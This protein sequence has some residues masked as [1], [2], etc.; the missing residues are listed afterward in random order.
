MPAVIGPVERR[1][2]E[3]YPRDFLAGL[4]GA[5]DFRKP[6][7]ALTDSL[8]MKEQGLRL[9]ADVAVP[10]RKN[11][12]PAPPRLLLIAPDAEAQTPAPVGVPRTTVSLE[13]EIIN[14]LEE[15]PLPGE[16]IADAFQRK[17]RV[18]GS[19]FA[20]LSVDDARSLHRRLCIPGKDDVIAARLARLTPERRAR[21][22]AFLGDAR[23]RAALGAR[24]G[25]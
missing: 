1:L 24:K 20:S 8:P 13:R 23:R 15:K 4:A 22:I 6:C 9:F 25:R 17:E 11:L 19:L 12:L 14:A 3:R 21:L 5:V 16:R 10:Q 7:F 18:V 2:R